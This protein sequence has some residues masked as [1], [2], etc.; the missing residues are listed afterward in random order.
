MSKYI[1][2]ERLRV[3]KI[4][5]QLV[6]AILCAARAVRIYDYNYIQDSTELIDTI[7]LLLS[8]Y[9]SKEKN[10]QKLDEFYASIE[11]VLPDLDEE[12]SEYGCSLY[13]GVAILY[14][15]DAVKD[16]S[17][18]TIL[19]SLN[20]TLEAVDGFS[21]YDGD[22]LKEEIKWQQEL[23]CVLEDKK[24]IAEQEILIELY[25]SKANWEA[26]WLD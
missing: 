1:F 17:L 8:E 4:E 6:F 14:A 10:I 25:K 3:L 18:E 7:Q 21:E 24:D 26:I 16:Y 15:I 19:Q 9:K 12:G 13:S 11:N 5:K 20:Y 2:E 22:G 23:L